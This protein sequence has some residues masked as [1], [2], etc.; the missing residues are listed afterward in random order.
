M[1]AGLLTGGAREVFYR[2][3]EAVAAHLDAGSGGSADNPRVSRALWGQAFGMVQDRDTVIDTTAFGQA[4]SYDLGTRQDWFGLQVGLDL[5]SGVRSAMGV[6]A[7]YADSRLKLQAA[8]TRIDYAAWNVGVYGRAEF[9][10]AFIRGLA[11]YER[12][13]ADFLVASAG[14]RSEVDGD[15]WGGWLELGA[16]FGG[17]RFF[18][19]PAASIEYARIDFDDFTAA[20]TGFAFDEEEGLRGK[21]GARFGAVID[22]SPSLVTVYGKVQAIHEFGGRDRFT[23]SNT[24]GSLAFDAPRTDTYGRATVGFS[25]S[26]GSGVSGFI[27]ASGDFAGGVSGVGARG[28]LSIRF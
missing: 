7:G 17:D 23:L 12:Y 5:M 28:G 22:T 15:G 8:P 14:V 3:N 25:A 21:A 27:E 6:T 9:G 1:G 4:R 16:R 18:V 10:A 20:G 11:K 2:G 19:E 26:T 13:S 24:G